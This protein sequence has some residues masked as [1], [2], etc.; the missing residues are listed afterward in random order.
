M[1]LIR[2]IK[3]HVIYCAQGYQYFNLVG[4]PSPKVQKGGFG[5][6]LMQYL[7]LVAEVLKR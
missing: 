5:A 3:K 2:S 4:C 6:F 1:G 7:D